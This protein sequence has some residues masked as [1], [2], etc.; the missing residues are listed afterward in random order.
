MGVGTA[1]RLKAGASG[2]NNA[3]SVSIKCD[4]FL[5][6]LSNVSFSTGA[7]FRGVNQC[8]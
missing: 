7:L 3:P 5:Y 6:K 8:Q 2:H 4:G 1:I